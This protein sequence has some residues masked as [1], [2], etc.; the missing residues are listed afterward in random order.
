MEKKSKGEEWGV[1]GGL[2][3]R[4][5][6]LRFLGLV[7]LEVEKLGGGNFFIYDSYLFS[8]SFFFFDS[9]LLIP[10]P[11][12]PLVKGKVKEEAIARVIKNELKMLMRKEAY[13]CNNFF[14]VSLLSLSPPFPPSL[15]SHPFPQE[16]F[17]KIVLDHLNLIFSD[18]GKTGEEGGGKTEVWWDQ[19]LP[20]NLAQFFCM[21]WPKGEGGR[22]M[23]EEE[24]VSKERLLKRIGLCF[25][26]FFFLSFFS[27]SFSYP[28]LQV[29]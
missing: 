2:H 22:E 10:S 9:L 20:F 15:L 23:L 21:E 14:K 4:G 19:D 6:N 29:S 12:D 26:F 11:L 13:S 27:S 7:L 18:V 24:G 16:L 17:K 3:E 1:M 5:V 25:F 8:L 28:C